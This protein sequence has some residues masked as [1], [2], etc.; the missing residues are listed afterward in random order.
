MDLSVSASQGLQ[1]AG[2]KGGAEERR[3]HLI[4][5]IK[6]GMN[7]K[8]HAVADVQGRPIRLFAT[9]GPVSDYSGAAAWLV[10]LS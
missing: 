3:G 10:P 4:G 2:E 5:R 9:A 7:A 1:P 6:G 8:L